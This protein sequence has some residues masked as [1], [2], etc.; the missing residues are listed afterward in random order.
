MV[1]DYWLK[2]AI[3]LRMSGTKPREQSISSNA[4]EWGKGT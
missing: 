2:V 4:T 1:K 3:T